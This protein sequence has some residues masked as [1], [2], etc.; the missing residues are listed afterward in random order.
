VFPNLCRLFALI[1][2]LSKC[3]EGLLLLESLPLFE[4]L[5]RAYF[6]VTFKRSYFIN[7]LYLVRQDHF[8]QCNTPPVSNFVFLNH[9]STVKA[10]TALRLFI[11]FFDES[12]ARSLSAPT[13][14][15]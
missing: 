14:P 3:A 10:L 7:G 15:A 1:V 5:F 2:Q 6:Y 4:Y 12:H 8:R 13:R 9:T 11:N